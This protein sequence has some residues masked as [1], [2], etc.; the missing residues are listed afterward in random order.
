MW[1]APSSVLPLP[2]EVTLASGAL[3]NDAPDLAP[4]APAQPYRKAIAIHDGM[5][6][7]PREPVVGG[8]QQH[9]SQERG[10]DV[11][12]TRGDLVLDRADGAGELRGR[13][14]HER[15]DRASDV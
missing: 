3:R 8:H 14:V 11:L 10:K 4:L 15:L 5:P 6:R 1:S 12:E 9:R 7:E 13:R 2:C